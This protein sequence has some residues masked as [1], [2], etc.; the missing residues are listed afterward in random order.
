MSD[1]PLYHRVGA[2]AKGLGGKKARQNL[3]TAAV[4]LNQELN[5]NKL[6]EPEDEFI[7]RPGHGMHCTHITHGFFPELDDDLEFV[8]YTS[9]PEDVKAGEILREYHEKEGT[10][11]QEIALYLY[12]K[13]KDIVPPGMKRK[14]EELLERS[15]KMETYITEIEKRLNT[16]SPSYES[17]PSKSH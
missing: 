3:V 8:Q 10:D 4:Y 12:H 7:Y 14:V 1:E 13:E 2:I 17:M 15:D 16:S 6:P 11:L 5:E 9:L